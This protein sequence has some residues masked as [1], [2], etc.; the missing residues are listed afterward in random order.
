MQANCF[1]SRGES[2]K[3]QES[4]SRSRHAPQLLGPEFM[5]WPVLLPQHPLLMLIHHVAD[6]ATKRSNDCGGCLLLEPRR[7]SAAF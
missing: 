3:S 2:Q 6:R 4:I 5:L 1:D 7:S